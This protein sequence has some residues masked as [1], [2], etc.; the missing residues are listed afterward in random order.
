MS[1]ELALLLRRK[2]AQ[3]EYAARALASD[4]N[5]SDEIVGFHARQAIEKLL[6]AVLAFR[7]IRFR[8]TH[9]IAEL[10]DLA[11][12]VEIPV[13]PFIEEARRLTPFAVDFRDGEL[14]DEGTP[15]DRAR[16]LALIDDAKE[17]VASLLDATST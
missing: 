6:K 4:P 13:P 3:D 12:D 14:S 17:W 11:V 10:L 2:A 9:D 15:F 7:G 16:A 5:A 1:R 8:R